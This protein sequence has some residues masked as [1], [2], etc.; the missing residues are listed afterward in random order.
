LISINADAISEH[1]AALR[2]RRTSQQSG[3]GRVEPPKS[4]DGI[5]ETIA[6]R[7]A[8]GGAH[9]IASVSTEALRQWFGE[10]PNAPASELPPHSNHGSLKCFN[11][12]DL[13]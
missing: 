1:S 6:S 4:P 5:E 13:H 10:D 11:F 9:T 7:Q 12:L 3:A 8:V 2:S